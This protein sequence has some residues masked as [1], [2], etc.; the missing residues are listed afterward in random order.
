MKSLIYQKKID[1]LNIFLICLSR[2]SKWKLKKKKNQYGL[3]KNI[4]GP[5]ISKPCLTFVCFLSLFFIVDGPLWFKRLAIWKYMID[6]WVNEFQPYIGTGKK[7]R[8]CDVISSNNAH[9]YAHPQGY[10]QYNHI[11]NR[12][13]GVTWEINVLT[14][15]NE[16][17]KTQELS[18]PYISSTN[19]SFFI[20]KI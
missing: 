2:R 5:H 8:G 3:C 11:P 16:F 6:L 18:V 4:Y 10:N 17:S 15:D 13:G 12:T 7:V 20:R 1:G 19:R 14:F 9:A